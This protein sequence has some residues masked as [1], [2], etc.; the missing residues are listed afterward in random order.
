MSLTAERLSRLVKYLESRP[1]PATSDDEFAADLVDYAAQLRSSTRGGGPRAPVS[2]QD[3]YE[4]SI[5][6]DLE[7]RQRS[8]IDARLELMEGTVHFIRW[9]LGFDDVPFPGKTRLAEVLVDWARGRLDPLNKFY[10][11]FRALLTK[12]AEEALLGLRPRLNAVN[13]AWSEEQRLEKAWRRSIEQLADGT[14]SLSEWIGC[15][16]EQAAHWILAGEKP[17]HACVQASA[18]SGSQGQTP[19]PWC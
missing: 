10:R 2:D 1:V 3:S 14:L 19:S 16:P 11:P 7:D 13:P 8:W 6:A 17:R 9:S 4:I 5:P 15:E 18:T 12:E